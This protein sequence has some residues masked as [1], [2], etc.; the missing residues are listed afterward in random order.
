MV[1]LKKSKERE[2]QKIRQ[3]REKKQF[4]I[5]YREKMLMVANSFENLPKMNAIDCQA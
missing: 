4:T 2:D 3:Y 1:R 5:N